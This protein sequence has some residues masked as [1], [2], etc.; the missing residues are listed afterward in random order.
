MKGFLP[1]FLSLFFLNACSIASKDNKRNIL[2]IKS[3]PE[4]ANV[5]VGQRSLGVT[6]L[7]IDTKTLTNE[8][9]D[10]YLPIKIS[11]PGYYS[12]KVYL[13]KADLSSINM[14]LKEISRQDVQKIVELLY[15]EDANLMTQNI[16]EIQALLMTRRYT[17]VKTKLQSFNKKYPHIAAGYT[18]MGSVL[19][20]EGNLEEARGYFSRAVGLN[21]KDQTA[22]RLLQILNNRSP[23]Q[24]NEQG[25][26]R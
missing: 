1:L 17:E 23:S 2:T 8:V 4:T 26:G 24:E 3:L 21:K 11:K 20:N 12:E 6:P 22:K 18:L 16:L 19:M 7:E 14:K 9:V 25:G 5:F 10:G 13:P 15:T